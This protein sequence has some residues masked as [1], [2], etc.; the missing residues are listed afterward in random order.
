MPW[1]LLITTNSPNRYKQDHVRQETS[2][3]S[4][5]MLVN[6]HKALHHFFFFNQ[7]F[8]LS[9]ALACKYFHGR[10][11]ASA[12]IRNSQGAF[13]NVHVQEALH[14]Q[15]YRGSAGEYQA[16]EQAGVAWLRD[17][18]STRLNSSHNA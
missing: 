1:F 15:E 11:Q 9:L 2:A 6:C 4:D 7:V 16:D 14:R 5:K 8:S 12:T 17:R 3:N 18:K 10:D 13:Y